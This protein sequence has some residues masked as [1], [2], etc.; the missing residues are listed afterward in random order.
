MLNKK[1]PFGSFL[2]K[3][4]RTVMFETI[5]A[6]AT[7]PFTSAISMIR[8][9]GDKALEI[10]SHCFQKILKTVKKEPF[11]MVLSWTKKKKSM[12]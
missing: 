6:L 7:A 4:R 10:V 11:I 9:S 12:K 8:V 2:L 3:E 1:E 5:V